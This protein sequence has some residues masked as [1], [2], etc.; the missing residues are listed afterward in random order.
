M[1]WCVKK[2][3][4]WVGTSLQDRPRRVPSRYKRGGARERMIAVTAT[5]NPGTRR[6][7][8]R[9]LDGTGWAVH[10]ADDPEAVV[11]LCCLHSADVV[12][13]DVDFPGGIEDLLA[14]VKTDTDLFRTAVVVVAPDLDA[15]AVQR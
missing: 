12:L 1:S 14:R 11:T 3:A 10:H 2:R 15:S 13:V 4:C 9:A 7:L 6:D 5:S 8:E